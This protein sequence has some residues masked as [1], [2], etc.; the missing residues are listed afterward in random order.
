MVNRCRVD[1]K[2]TLHVHSGRA[3]V[4]LPPQY[5][6]V[7]GRAGGWIC[8]KHNVPRSKVSNF[9]GTLQFFLLRHVTTLT[10]TSQLFGIYCSRH[11]LASKSAS[12]RLAEAK[13]PIEYDLIPLE[14]TQVLCSAENADKTLKAKRR[15]E[16]ATE[17]ISLHPSFPRLKWCKSGR[18]FASLTGQDRRI[19]SG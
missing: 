5:R 19:F 7:G 18:Y 15:F 9:G 6:R 13:G 11:L 16:L 14:S 12:S 4:A 2:T 3:H 8:P 17:G 10:L 1:F